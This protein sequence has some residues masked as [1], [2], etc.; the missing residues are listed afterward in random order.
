[1]TEA[2]DEQTLD[3]TLSALLALSSLSAPPSATDRLSILETATPLLAQLKS[4]NR[5][6]Y[7]TLNER[8]A[9]V[10]DARSKV[11]VERLKLQNYEYEKTMLK[12]EVWACRMF[13]SIYQDVDLHSEEEFLQIAPEDLKT[14]EIRN[15][16]H[17]FMLSRL[18]FELTERKRLEAEKQSLQ[19]QKSAVIRESK[20]KK[21]KLEEAEKELKELLAAAKA[22]GSKFDNT[23]TQQQQEQPSSADAPAAEASASNPAAASSA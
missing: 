15:D 9:K 14:D 11:D 23:T 21:I 8:K 7:T 12:I 2:A 13:Q 20:E 4:T 1:M 22:V 10:N 16:P 5:S 18:K 19:S 17:L 6:I 3:A